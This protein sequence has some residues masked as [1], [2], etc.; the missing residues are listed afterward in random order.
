MTLADNIVTEAR[1]WKNTPFR[2]QG[3]LKGLGVDCAGFM[4][5][6]ARNA[7][8]ANVDIP[9]DYKPQEDGTAM[10]R[11]LSQHLDFVPTEDVRAGDVLA[12]CDEALR[13]PDIPRHLAFVTE[14]KAGTIF[15]IHAS[16]HGVREHRTNEHWRKRIHSVWRLRDAGTS[17][18][19]VSRTRSKKAKR[20]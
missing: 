16:E 6:V 14:V 4:G 1:T 20:A 17:K 19:T 11:L 13:F 7:G 15:L 10:M 8:V 9:N 18:K 2:H 12:L 5:E 3:R